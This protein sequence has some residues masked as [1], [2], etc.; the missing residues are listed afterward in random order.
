MFSF[1]SQSSLLYEPEITDQLKFLNLSQVAN[2]TY[3][4]AVVIHLNSNQYILY[5]TFLAALWAFLAALWIFLAA[6]WA[7]LAALWVFL[8]DLL[9]FLAALWV[10]LVALWVFFIPLIFQVFCFHTRLENLKQLEKYNVVTELKCVLNLFSK[11]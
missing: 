10:F 11:K 3:G 4:I 2:T 7:F 9:A 8:A 6:L 5:L 1:Y